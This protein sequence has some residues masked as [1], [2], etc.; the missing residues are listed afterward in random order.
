MK[1]LA[2]SM[3]ETERL[4]EKLRKQSN[5]GR[6]LVVEAE[7]GIY[8]NRRRVMEYGRSTDFKNSI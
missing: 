1:P 3:K 8:S 6:M 4:I 7:N 2:Q 5:Q